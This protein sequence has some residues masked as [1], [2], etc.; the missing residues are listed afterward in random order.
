MITLYVNIR[1]ILKLIQ[2]VYILHVHDYM[3]LLVE[4]SCVV[5]F[6]L[7]P[8]HKFW[9]NKH[10]QYYYFFS[11]PLYFNFQQLYMEPTHV[12]IC[13]TTSTHSYKDCT[14]LTYMHTLVHNHTRHT[15]HL[16][17]HAVIVG[18]RVLKSPHAYAFS[19]SSINIWV[20]CNQFLHT[21]TKNLQF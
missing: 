5:M 2:S 19:F 4:F 11:M 6:K 21:Q 12:N 18:E 13:F 15:F 10:R 3:R 9:Q 7:S 8:R 16:Q 1:I 14:L 17:L 20:V